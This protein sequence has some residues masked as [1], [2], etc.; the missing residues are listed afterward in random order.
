MAS[1]P[2]EI[3]FHHV[4]GYAGAL[5]L[6]IPAPL[7][8]DVSLYLYDANA[9]TMEQLG[10]AT[11]YRRQMNIGQAVF[12]RDGKTDVHITYHP[13]GS[14]LFPLSPDF[15]AYWKDAYTESDMCDVLTSDQR[16][17][18]TVPVVCTTM[19]SVCRTHGLGLDFL[20]LDAEGSEKQILEGAKTALTNSVVGLICEIHFIEVRTGQTS[21]G[22]LFSHAAAQGF[23]LADLRMHP[24]RG[25]M[26]LPLGWRAEGAVTS[27]DGFFFKRL[28]TLRATYPK[29]AVALAKLAMFCLLAGRLEHGVAAALAAQEADREV[30]A[31][32]IDF[33]YIR[34]LSEIVSLYQKEDGLFLPTWTDFYPTAEAGNRH[35]DPDRGIDVRDATRRYFSRV[36]PVAFLQCIGA[37]SSQGDSALE[38]LLRRYGLDDLANAVKQHRQRSLVILLN[39]LGLIEKD[40]PTS[41][42]TIV[43]RIT[44]RL[45]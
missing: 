35:G 45:A 4:G 20:S 12:D 11:E 17:V 10:S 33:A 27:G 9:A 34:L 38:S 41:P 13:A 31:E 22:D 16:E 14:S 24:G 26:R 43:Q 1:N 8:R 39:W 3:H 29:P 19:D 5:P 36:Q 42:Q 30:F 7:R 40:K 37:L 21:A 18:S 32:G 15:L 23:H 25:Y 2:Y 28:D 44:E 6:P